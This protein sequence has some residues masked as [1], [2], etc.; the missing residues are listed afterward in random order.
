[1]RVKEIGRHVAWKILAYL[2]TDGPVEMWVGEQKTAKDGVLGGSGLIWPIDWRVVVGVLN[3][4]R[5]EGV[6][7]L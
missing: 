1:M 2:R 7:H 6:Y 3:D 4:T 5:L